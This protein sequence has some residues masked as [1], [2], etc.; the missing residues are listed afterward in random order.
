MRRDGAKIH[1]FRLS[2]REIFVRGQPKTQTGLN[3]F[4]KFQFARRRFGDEKAR[5]PKRSS[6]KSH[7]FCPTGKSTTRRAR[8]R[9]GL[10]K[11]H[12]VLV[13]E[14]MSAFGGMRAWP[15]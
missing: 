1:N 3:R 14:F 11:G 7:R 10:A 6:E 15:D 12:P 8:S 13:S 9:R 4:N 2:E 5:R